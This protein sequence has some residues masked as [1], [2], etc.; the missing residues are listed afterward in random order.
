MACRARHFIFA[1]RNQYTT[2]M[3]TKDK[4]NRK[5]MTRGFVKIDRR[6]FDYI[7]RA[8]PL[9]KFEALADLFQLT[10]NT[11]SLVLKTHGVS[12]KLAHGQVLLSYSDCRKR[13]GWSMKAVRTFIDNMVGAEIIVPQAIIPK[14][15]TVYMLG[16]QKDSTQKGTVKVLDASHLRESEDNNKGAIQGTP[17]LLDQDNNIYK[18]ENSSFFPKITS[19]EDAQ[20]HRFETW[21]QQCLPPHARPADRAMFF[22]MLREAGSPNVMADALIYMAAYDIP[23]SEY[24]TTLNQKQWTDEHR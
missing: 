10:V 4:T 8:R 23:L 16:A 5:E 15:G 12:V 20:Y 3:E 17:Y 7:D 18:K 9:T 19:P 22:D 6:C 2:I 14:V 1:P 13:W 24:S 11:T 21:A